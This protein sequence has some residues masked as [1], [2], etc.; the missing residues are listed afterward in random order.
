MATIALVMFPELG[1]VHGAT[2]LAV[3]LR[4]AGHDV[5]AIGGAA[6]ELRAAVEGAGVSYRGALGTMAWD[7]DLGVTR[8][9]AELSPAVVLADVNLKTTTRLGGR[10]AFVHTALPNVRV[11]GRGPITTAVV[12]GD[13]LKSRLAAAAAWQLGGARR[14]PPWERRHDHH[15]ALVL[16]PREFDP[17]ADTLPPRYVWLGPC[18]DT[19]RREPAM[20]PE[21]AELMARSGPLVYC[22]FGSQ[23]HRMR[24]RE[25]LIRAVLAAARR[26]PSWRFAIATGGA[27]AGDRL[28]AV[29]ANACVVATCPQLAML[30]CAQVMITHAGFNSVKECIAAGVPMLALPLD[31]DQPGNAAR[32]VRLGL[33]VTCPA[34]ATE[35]ADA[36]CRL[37]FDPGFVARVVG[38]RAHTAYYAEQRVAAAAVERMVIAEAA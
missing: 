29:P 19:A 25:A 14:L 37:V 38:F 5:V 31:H 13:T 9:L 16:A 26:L 28:G 34:G 22:A 7:R 11:P 17:V 3:Q 8:V 10:V 12:G 35:L 4:D 33:G 21:L 2:G 1:H 30:A 18:V 23:G 15:P 32:V 27:V 24:G 36:A 6:D 20:P